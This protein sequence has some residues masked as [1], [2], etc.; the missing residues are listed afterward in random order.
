MRSVISRSVDRLLHT[1]ALTS[2]PGV[3]AEV[4]AFHAATPV[5][6]LVVGTP[7]FR[8]DLLRRKRH[9]HVDL[10]R[11]EAGGVDLVGFTIATRHPD[12]R[13]TLSTPH[14]WSLGL[15][16]SERATDMAICGAFLD[17]IEAWV[18]ASAGRLRRVTSRADLSTLSRP[19]SGVG[20]FV[21]VQG[22]HVLD[23]EPANVERLRDRGVRMLA[24]AHVMDNALVGSNTGRR[25][26]GLTGLGREVIAEAERVGVA[27]DLAHMSPAGI[28]DTLPL[29]QRTFVLSH[30]GFVRLSRQRSRIPGRHF[31]RGNRNLTDADARAVADAGGVIGLTLSTRLLG[32]ED[33]DA[34]ARAV[35]LGLDLAGPERLAL[36]SD[37][38]GALRM[39]C[40]A[41]GLPH[42]TQRLLAGGLDRPTVTAFLGGNALR[43]LDATMP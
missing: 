17:R 31:T 2:P 22:G 35:D 11:L 6:D 5:V 39:V 8:T 18:E 1:T 4:A 43:V 34:V 38:D 37:M 7:L 26:H 36:G 3:D 20:I 33:L 41:A 29:L 9:G 42:V 21:G 32:G 25:K 30:T 16:R 28:A 12:L 40:D 19:R 24:L 23:G 15:S 10:P 13:G 14:F 27:V